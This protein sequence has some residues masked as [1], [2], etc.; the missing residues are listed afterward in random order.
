MRN[1]EVITDLIVDIAQRDERIRASLLSGSR[2]DPNAPRDRF[3]DF[4]VVYVVTDV[5]SFRRDPTWID[6]FGEL[7]I[8]QTPED[9]LSPPPS[10]GGYYVY[11]MQL[12]DG[13]RIDL[14]L[15]P[16][17]QLGSFKPDSSSVLLLDK[18][19]MIGPL[20]P[21]SDRDYLPKPPSAKLYADCCNEFWWVIIYVAK[22]LWRKE[23]VY[24]KTAL[25]GFVRPQ[26]MQMLE[27]Y[28]GMKTEFSQNPGKFG[29]HFRRYLEP[30]VWALLE[31][32][33][34]DARY[35]RSWEALFAATDL[36]RH[37]AVRVAEPFG[38][39]Y[40][41]GEDEKISAYLREVQ[42]LPQSA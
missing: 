37:A 12:M 13:N 14:T 39:E 27:W 6:P 15:Y 30:D 3:Q 35:E 7:M 10:G 19:G 42:R 2:A 36:F 31:R 34:A 11:L 18:D 20:P 4:D 24:A 26:L 25:D 29:K 32:T 22:G 28:I 33:Y 21:P 1:E 17:A 40:P 41:F 23:I 16:L 5:S 9:M 8:L 38:F